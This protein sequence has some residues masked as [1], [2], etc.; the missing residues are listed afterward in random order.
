MSPTLDPGDRI[1]YLKHFNHSINNIVLAEV[2]SKRG[3]F[4]KRV[5]AEGQDHLVIDSHELSVNGR[6]VASLFAEASENIVLPASTV[7]LLGDN[8]D[9]SVDSRE[10]GPIS[11]DNIKGV[12]VIKISGLANFHLLK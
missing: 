6:L 5:V 4:I 3:L 12:A 10:W 1:I 9:Y 2:D 11:T 7:Y 8:V